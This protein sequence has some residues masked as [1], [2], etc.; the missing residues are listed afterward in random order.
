ML[1]KFSIDFKFCDRN[2]VST[3]ILN[4]FFFFSFKDRPRF[5]GLF[6]FCKLL[7]NVGLVDRIRVVRLFYFVFLLLKRRGF[8]QDV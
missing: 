8:I 3:L 6:V 7:R 5:G 2:V 4:Q 1:G